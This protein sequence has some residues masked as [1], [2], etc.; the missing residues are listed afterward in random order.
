MC[1][2]ADDEETKIAMFG[3]QTTKRFPVGLVKTW[4]RNESGLDE[5]PHNKSIHKSY[6][7]IISRR[8]LMPRL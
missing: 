7:N 8:A 5:L 6:S 1:A 4:K 2:W 3:L